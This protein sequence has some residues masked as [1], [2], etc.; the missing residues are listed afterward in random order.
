MA[1][2]SQLKNKCT[3]TLLPVTTILIALSILWL[4]LCC[5]GATLLKQTPTKTLLKHYQ[6][7]ISKCLLLSTTFAVFRIDLANG[8]YFHPIIYLLA[9]ITSMILY[10]IVA[11]MDP[12]YVKRGD[13]D[14]KEVSFL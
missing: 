13:P 10:F 2:N 11:F 3:S 5:P 9:V 4:L 8:Y 1:G 7:V 14:V 12:G 6:A